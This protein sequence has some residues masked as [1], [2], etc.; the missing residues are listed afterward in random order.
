MVYHHLVKFSGHR[1]C[2]SKGYTFSLSRDQVRTG[3]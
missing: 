2:S 3:D 1:Y